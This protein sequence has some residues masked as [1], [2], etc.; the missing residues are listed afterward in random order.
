MLRFPKILDFLRAV[1][2]NYRLTQVDGR[3]GAFLLY[4]VFSGGKD[5]PAPVRQG[6]IGCQIGGDLKLISYSIAVIPPAVYDAPSLGIVGI[7]GIAQRFVGRRGNRQCTIRVLD[8]AHAAEQP[9]ADGTVAVMIQGFVR[10]S[11]FV[12]TRP[13]FPSGR[14]V[15]ADLIQPT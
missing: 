9:A 11:I 3:A 1:V 15:F 2:Y 13:G 5:Q 6:G 4:Y 12:N 8:A 7:L 10:L 14:G